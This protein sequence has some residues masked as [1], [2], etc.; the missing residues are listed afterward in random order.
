MKLQLRPK[1]P[2]EGEGEGGD[3]V[4]ES[5]S[6]DELPVDDLSDKDNYTNEPLEYR[7]LDL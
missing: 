3:S 2:S 7:Q 4:V 5:M 1:P 6:L